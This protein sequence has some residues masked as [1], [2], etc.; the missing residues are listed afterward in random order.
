[1]LIVIRDPAG[2]STDVDIAWPGF[3]GIIGFWVYRRLVKTSFALCQWHQPLDSS[4]SSALLNFKFDLIPDLWKNV[5]LYD[6]ELSPEMLRKYVI[7]ALLRYVRFLV[8]L[9][10]YFRSQESFEI[11]LL[12]A[13]TTRPFTFT[14]C[15]MHLGVTS[16]FLGVERTKLY[17][18]GIEAEV[19]GGLA[20][21]RGSLAY[22]FFSL[23]SYLFCFTF[24]AKLLAWVITDFRS[25]LCYVRQSRF[26][27]GYTINPCGASFD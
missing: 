4:T 17:V 7:F 27:L 22:T 12:D 8:P 21:T 18:G 23:F 16:M 3:G 20:H 13:L 19:F 25:D 2:D 6:F 9:T 26:E 5:G 11:G 24:L 10:L 14:D 15:P 1:M